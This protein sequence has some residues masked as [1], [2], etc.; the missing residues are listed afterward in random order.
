MEIK[1]MTDL[2]GTLPKTVEFNYEELDRQ[3]N[4]M[5]EKYK[6]KEKTD[7]SN[8][9]RRKEERA[10]LNKLSSALD[11]VR[12]DVKKRLLAVME[13][14]TRDNPSF[15]DKMKSL[16]GLVSMVSGEID[17]G[18]K[19]YEEGVKGQLRESFICFMSTM[20]SRILGADWEFKSRNWLRAWSEEQMTRK[21]GCWLNMGVNEDDVYREI[22][23]EINRIK[24]QIDTL[25]QVLVTKEDE[26]ITRIKA[27]EALAVKFDVS[28]AI[29]AINESREAIKLAKEREEEKRRVELQ[30][31]SETITPTPNE[32]GEVETVRFSCEMRF[33]G[34]MEAFVNLR[35]YLEM[36]K[37]INYVVTRS[38]EPINK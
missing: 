1:L 13:D 4:E 16:I 21:K 38:M 2:D 26:E 19:E 29:M 25:E 34:T 6:G 27:R 36:N 33:V 3:L 30:K 23:S 5:L 10:S 35:A 8:Y 28:D 11:S 12:K 24:S 20:S 18:I 17:N 15:T 31:M 14:G 22:E 7:A 32:K 37:D 9:K